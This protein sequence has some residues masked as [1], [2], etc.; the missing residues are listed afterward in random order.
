LLFLKNALR[1][2]ALIIVLTVAGGTLTASH[3]LSLV[4]APPTQIAHVNP[5][6]KHDVFTV[7]VEARLLEA[8]ISRELTLSSSSPRVSEKAAG[9]VVTAALTALEA[10]VNEAKEKV[11][12]DLPHYDF[13]ILGGQA[14]TAEYANKY[15]KD[16]E[17]AETERNEALE[18]AIVA[19]ETE[20]AA[21]K[22][23][24]RIAEEK[25]K[26]EE[27]AAA[28][29]KAARSS[30]SSAP[31]STGL[32]AGTEDFATRIQ[33]VAATLPFA[34]PP[35]SSGSCSQFA[36]AWGCFTTDNRIY[37]TASGMKQNDCT[38]RMI[39]AHEYRHSVQWNTGLVILNELGEIQN[40]EWL[41]SDAYAFGNPY[42][43]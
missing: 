28:A 30:K 16:I 21:E 3:P 25:R 4:E 10:Q 39:L 9:G 32:Y 18:T 33:R 31:R 15:I 36:T 23:R 2:V 7:S 43:C 35:V 41:E 12:S 38:L 8:Y 37:V 20:L 29:A 5:I 34:V 13:L 14:Y 19:W 42:R 40:R 24:I 27:A 11:M 1:L 22:E 6:R 26:A 17:K